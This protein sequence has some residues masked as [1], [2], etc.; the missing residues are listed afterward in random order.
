M[1]A[2]VG[3]SPEG[4]PLVTIGIVTRNRCGLLRKAVASALAQSWPTKEVVVVDDASSDGTPGLAREF[5][6]VRWIRRAAPGGYMSARNEMMLGSQA[7]YFCGLDDDAWF[8]GDDA[9]EAS[10]RAMEANPGWGAVAFDILDPRRP[11]PVERRGAIPVDTFI[12]CGHLLRLDVMRDLGGYVPMPGAY[13][14]EEKDLSLR[15]LDKGMEV[16]RLPGV[17]VWHE[18]SSLA[19]D[20]REQHAS[21]ICNDLALAWLRYP[22]GS[23]VWRLPAKVASQ[24]RFAIRMGL[25][26]PCLRGMARAIVGFPSVA[27]LRNPVS[28]A[29]LRES[30]RSARRQS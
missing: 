22:A 12:G 16:V 18:K 17:H 9:L 1:T 23:L 13:G 19:R 20:A 21:A 25:V 5:L 4:Q 26:G 11:D 28:G 30:L 3:D 15:L 7:K 6:S 29:A 24:L 2:S 10:V 8:V 27:R 14:F